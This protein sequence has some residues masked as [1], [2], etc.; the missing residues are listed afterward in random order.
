MR[1][2]IKENGDGKGTE[3][4]GGCVE[5][6]V[7]LNKEGM[8]WGSTRKSDTGLTFPADSGGEEVV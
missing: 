5:K 2:E 1:G 6:A 8:K 4:M 3:K 7:V